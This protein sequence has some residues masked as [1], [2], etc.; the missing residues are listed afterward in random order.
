M[1]MQTE[2]VD[3]LESEMQ[4]LQEEKRKITGKEKELAKKERVRM[5]IRV[6]Q[7]VQARDISYTY[8]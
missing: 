4:R 2:E 5:Y 6:C 7:Y 3:K 8:F 1:Y